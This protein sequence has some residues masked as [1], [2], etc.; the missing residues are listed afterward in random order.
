MHP[1]NAISM[2]IKDNAISMTIK[3]N[4]ISMTIKDNAISMTIKDNAIS[5]TIK[6]NAI[7]MTI[8]DNAISMTIK[9]NAIS[10]TIKA[11]TSSYMTQLWKGF[12]QNVYKTCT[13]MYFVSTR[14]R[15]IDEERL[16]ARDVKICGFTASLLLGLYMRTLHPSVPGGDSGELTVLYP[17]FPAGTR[18]S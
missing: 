11:Y 18:V 13:N 3:D 15:A 17:L 12:C 6:D 9:D 8:K 1:D 5:M 7:S 4:A 14:G 16:W 10:K 2:T